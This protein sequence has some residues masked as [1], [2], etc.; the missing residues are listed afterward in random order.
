MKILLSNRGPYRRLDERPLQR[1]GGGLSQALLQNGTVLRD[2]SVLWLYPSNDGSR[3]QLYSANMEIVEIKVDTELHTRHYDFANRYLWF[4]LHSLLRPAELVYDSNFY[5][6]L[7]SYESFN[8]EFAKAAAL[9]IKAFLS[10]EKRE[11]GELEILV[12]DYHFFSLPALLKEEL[13]RHGIANSIIFFLHTAWP[14]KEYVERVCA[15]QVK[16][17]V[18]KMLE[19]ADRVGFLADRWRGNFLQLFPRESNKTFTNPLLVDPTASYTSSQLSL[20]EEFIPKRLKKKFIY[21]KLDRSDPIK[22]AINSLKAYA[23]AIESDLNLRE[24]SIFVLV[25]YG[26]RTN[27]TEYIELAERTRLELARF[28]EKYG[29]EQFL[30]FDDDNMKRSLSLYSAA[31]C[32]V[33]PSL[34]DGMNLAVQEALLLSKQKCIPILSERMGIT[35][36]ISSDALVVS[37]YEVEEISEAMQECFY[38]E[39][40]EKEKRQVSLQKRLAVVSG[41]WLKTCFERVD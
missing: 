33:A 40:E 37:P 30:F 18:F 3:K 13:S 24:N 2:D 11:G 31:D 15:K 12:N 20:G 8:L 9:E 23:L 10:T 29:E 39:F 36:L 28:R 19:E 14:E 7:A 41:A 4:F 22:N 21:L 34:A 35:E 25:A 38:M 27:F 16:E 32:I 6:G 1:G 5:T 26:S 17:R